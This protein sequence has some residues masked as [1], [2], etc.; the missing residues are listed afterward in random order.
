MKFNF[1]NSVGRRTKRLFFFFSLL[2]S[3]LA[4]MA[5]VSITNFTGTITTPPQVDATSFVNS[6][7][8]NIFTFQAPY[9]TANTLNYTNTGTMKGSLGWEFDYGPLPLGGRG[10]SANFYND[11]AGTIQ[12]VD[13]YIYNPPNTLFSNLVSYLLVSATNIV[14]KGTLIAG[15]SGEMILT[16]TNVS[17][18]RSGLEIL[19]IQGQGTSTTPTNFI[20]ENGIYDEYWIAGSNILTVS[21][22]PWTGTTL[23]TFTGNNAGEPCGVSNAAIKIG[24]LTPQLEDS[25]TNAL[26][27]YFVATTNS[28]G[29]AGQSV[30]VYSNIVRQ[31]VFVAVSDPGIT[32]AVRFNAALVQTN[33]FKTVAAQFNMV[34]TNVVTQALQTNSLYLVDDLA[35][36]TNQ[37]VLTNAIIN[38]AAEC[39]SPTARPSSVIV[40]RT[41]P[42]LSFVQSSGITITTNAFAT[43][44]SGLGSPPANFFY[45]STTFSNAVAT[46][47]ADAY[48]ALVDNVAAESSGSEG[49]SL[50][51]Q[52]GRIQIYA[53]NLDLTKTRMDDEG[54][55]ITIVAANLTNSAGAEI[56]CQNLSFNLGSTN[57]FLN[58]TNL[59]LSYVSR[60]HGTIDEWS[61]LWTN[62]MY[63]VITNN[64]AP[65]VSGPLTNWVQSPLT[66][67]VQMDL[68]ITV[69]D[70]SNLVSTV[71]VT[72]QDLILNSTNIVVSDY[73]TV[74]QTL[75]LNGQSFTLLGVGGITL[76]S[77]LLDWAY[78]NAP[79]LRYFT[80]DGT[81]TIPN[82]AHFGDDGPTNYLEFV[83]NGGISAGS[84]TINTVDFQQN[85]GVQTVHGG[86]Y[87]TASSAKV[88]LG[89]ISS[90]QDIRFSAN[91]LQLS[92]LASLF[93]GG[94]LDFAVTTNL[95]DTGA[96]SGNFFTCSNGFNLSIKPLTGD[97]HGTTLE[98]I[99]PTFAVVNHTWAGK[100]LGATLAGFSNNVAIG[101]LTLVA[102]G[103]GSS[104]QEPEFVFSGTGAS[105]GLYVD[106]LDLSQLGNYNFLD[107][108]LVSI[109]PNLTIYFASASTNPAVLNGQFGGHLVWVQAAAVQNFKLSTASYTNGAFQFSIAGQS[110]Q[111]NIIQASTNLLNWVP[112]YTN[113][114]STNFTDPSATNYPRRFY[115]DFLPGL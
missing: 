6:G 62:Y 7:T 17:L 84:E 78:T 42:I 98:T 47:V 38:P 4:V 112:I 28:M 25:Y 45:D 99:A 100:D 92:N 35:S 63:V 18:A 67:S 44:F 103:N 46:G 51:N 27:P 65:V 86:F 96:G 89:V 3:P 21:G 30:S 40:S 93:A 60:L 57:G 114:G 76:E 13:G 9:E 32:P 106:Y 56:S 90:G 41:D 10:M 15:A 16:G 88:A 39:S 74:D 55:Q 69:V 29:N 104:I 87:L 101:H 82:E 94:A 2:L 1:S 37:I 68:A 49:D 31:A 113:V 80:N 115:R 22:S 72:V 108:S 66:N 91:T 23:G 83:N 111:T 110:G 71:P 53:D 81:L 105:N 19:S 8:W 97:L 95:S 73:M 34:S 70:A 109:S 59:A 11:N 107:G 48:S 14:N 58:I 24:P 50:T 64:F 26:N 61:G 102:G 77:P 5:T 20:P 43:G 33:F 52:P 85:A 79:T 36:S 75:Q 54:S 12:A